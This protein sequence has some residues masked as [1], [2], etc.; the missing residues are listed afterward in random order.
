MGPRWVEGG[1][2]VGDVVRE[3]GSEE[4]RYLWVSGE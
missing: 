3:E 2:G 1:D 4:R